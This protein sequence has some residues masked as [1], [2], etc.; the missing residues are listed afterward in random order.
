MHEVFAFIYI[1][2]LIID[3]WFCFHSWPRRC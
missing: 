1:L 3:R 2:I